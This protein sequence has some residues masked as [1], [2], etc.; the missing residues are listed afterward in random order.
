MPVVLSPADGTVNAS[1]SAAVWSKTVGVARPAKHKFDLPELRSKFPH[2]DLAVEH[3]RAKL[4]DSAE[5]E[6]YVAMCLSAI[7]TT[8]RGYANKF[9]EFATVFCKPRNLCPLPADSVTIKRYIGWQGKKGTVLGSSM[10]QYLSA[11]NFFHRSI[12]LPAPCPTDAKGQYAADVRNAIVGMT[13]LQIA[14]APESAERDH[15]YLP[16][17]PIAGILDAMLAAQLDFDFDSQEAC[18]N[19]RQDM[20]SVFNYVDFARSDSGA[21]MKL[22]DVA[23]DDVE[24]VLLFRLRKVKGTVSRRH[25][26]TFQWPAGVLT[27]VKRAFQFYLRIRDFVGAPT[28]PT[29]LLWKL[30]WDTAALNAQT[31]AKFKLASLARSGFSFPGN[32]DITAHAWRGGPASEAT[33]IGVSYDK[34]CVV[35]DWALGSAVPR[36]NY[37]D[38]TCPP[39]PAGGRFFGYLRPPPLPT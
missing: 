23:M 27:D 5:A 20:C 30:P 1:A 14:A 15:T 32:F 34:V 7:G 38:F 9:T 3:Y 13:K 35:G 33:A 4:G 22:C 17:A 28:G 25:H 6:Y 19:Y 2:Y 18:G 36:Q 21:P 12:E 8:A 29:S 10:T 37:I 26:L 16:A 11:I 31:F 39:S 24:D